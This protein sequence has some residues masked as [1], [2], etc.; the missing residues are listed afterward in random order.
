MRIDTVIALLK[1][2]AEHVPGAQWYLFGSVLTD[3]SSAIDVDVLVI[4][5]R[6]EDPTIIR[7]HL[8]QFHPMLPVHLLF[9]SRDEEDEL[10]F[11]AKQGCLRVFPDPSQGCPDA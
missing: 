7:Q 2:V 4:Y 8:S 1:G 11:I 6:E 5:A 9:L 10:D 3:C